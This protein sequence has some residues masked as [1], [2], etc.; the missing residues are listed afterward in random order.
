[1]RNNDD[2][3]LNEIKDLL[4]ENDPDE[5]DF[6]W[7]RAS[8]EET[9]GV[10]VPQHVPSEYTDPMRPGQR[11][12]RADR[13]SV[14]SMR[15][16]HDGAQVTYRQA[17]EPTPV[18]QPV[19]QKKRKKRSVFRTVR[20]LILLAILVAILW[21]VGLFV[22]A[23][24]PQTDQPIAAR[25]SGCASILLCGTDMDGTRTDAMMLLFIDRDARQLRLLSLPRDTMVNR[26][27]P[28]PKL[29]GAYSAN[30]SGTK[31]MDVLM[32]Y[33]K[34]LV[35][36]RPDGYMLVDLNCFTELVD[37][38][39]GVSFD[40]PMDMKYDDPT[41]GLHIDLSKGLQELTGQEAMWLVRFRSGYTMA[42]LDRIDVQRSFLFDAF[43]QWAKPSKIFR[44]PGAL[45]LLKNNTLTDL[46]AS[47]FR[48]IAV[49]VALC[50]KN[51]VASDTLPGEPTYVNGGAYYVEDREAVAKL[52]N[53]RYNP[54]EKEISPNDLH[55]YGH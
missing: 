37:Q 52:I 4:N 38:M 24:M 27:N 19:R 42:D 30:G 21:V 26:T 48:W 25:K 12:V 14:D 39:G 8:F 23:K 18:S 22:F 2:E 49:S 15:R 3:L 10:P 20:R 45:R 50:V 9:V 11:Q 47:N 35:G 1:M 5:S 46:S 54:Y 33:V 40:V 29:N 44:L 28:V 13:Y 53:E 16:V 41:Q 36:Y 43:K 55:P 17:P 34:D 6:S 31:G 51:G 32:D 7:E